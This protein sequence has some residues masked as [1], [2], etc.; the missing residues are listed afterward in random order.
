MLKDRITTIQVAL[1][2]YTSLVGVGYLAMP[3]RLAETAGR[4]GWVNLLLGGMLL[5]SVNA[6]LVWLCR[7][8]PGQTIIEYS[9]AILGRPLG[10]A[11]NILL[12]LHF[13]L[14][15]A[16]VSRIF[17]DVIKLYLLENTPL[18]VILITF[19]LTGAYLAGHGL[20]PLARM[21]EVMFPLVLA[22]ILLILALAQMEIDYGE[23]LPVMT[24]GLYPVI[25][26]AANSFFVYTGFILT[27]FLVAFMQQPEKALK[28]SS[29]GLAGTIL[30][31][32]VIF[33]VT[34]SSLGEAS[35][36]WS[37]YP[38]ADLA[39]RI[40]VPGAFLEKLEAPLMALWVLTAFT[41]MTP[42]LYFGTLS[43]SQM[44]GLK[45]HRGLVYLFLPV[46][47]Q[48]AMLPRNY[49]ETILLGNIMGYAALAFIPVIILL[50]L[51]AK[52]RKGGG[53]NG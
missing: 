29:L 13:I 25:Q 2:L 27:A 50:A 40:E 31:Y 51:V 6:L 33:I 42:S 35:L 32:L 11:A 9:Q 22:P 19:F 17:G 21:S 44:L 24:I 4:D 10:Q 45:E 3:R 53:G 48:V 43:L 39:R 26:G 47:Y 41:T 36:Y 5:L 7:R 12:V 52:L 49:G 28:A 15:A 8:Y 18:E 14:M 34:L 16:S 20:N 37:T 38:V 46:V 1:L 30:T 23:V